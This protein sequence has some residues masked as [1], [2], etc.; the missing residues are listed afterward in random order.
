MIHRF[1]LDG[2]DRKNHGILAS[3]HESD[4]GLGFEKKNPQK[5]QYL[6]NFFPLI[7]SHFLQ[8]FKPEVHTRFWIF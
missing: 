5:S 2:I 4:M 7:L 3:E 1:L 6:F 8:R